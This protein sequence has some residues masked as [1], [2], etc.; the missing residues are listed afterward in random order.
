M[1]L[2]AGWLTGDWALALPLGMICE[3]FWLDVLEVGSVLAPS[4]CFSFL[5]L[6]PLA[7]HLGLHE[8]GSLAL[9]LLLALL[10][11]TL[12]AKAEQSLRI[13]QNRL[14]AQVEAHCAGEA[15]GLSPALA[16][17]RM[18]LQRALIHFLLYCACFVLLLSVMRWAQASIALA[19]I[20]AAS[21][22]LLLAAALPGAVLT[23]RAR[24]FYLIL[25]GGLAFCLGL[26]CLRGV[27]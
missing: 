5:L 6:F 8:A 12:V 22:P 19:A 15:D 9:P 13:S 27:A 24:N 16:V 7:R 26:I 11:G 18:A 23:L 10:L 25:L 21:W 17:M 20:P 1:A 3:L 14:V 2:L 4:G